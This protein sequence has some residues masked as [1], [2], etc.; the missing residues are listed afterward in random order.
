MVSLR[1]ARLRQG[2]ALRARIRPMAL[3]MDSSLDSLDVSAGS[4]AGCPCARC[5]QTKVPSEQRCKRRLREAGVGTAEGSAG[6]E[7]AGL[8]SEPRPLLPLPAAL[9]TLAQLQP[10]QI[11]A[12]GLLSFSG[13]LLLGRQF[14]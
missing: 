3:S 8:P 4:A 13:A 14:K 6:S 1:E 10:L 2:N 7:Q 12:A 9:R 5:L 11:P